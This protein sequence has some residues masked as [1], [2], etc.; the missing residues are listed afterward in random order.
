[1][2]TP[3]ASATIK[4]IKNGSIVDIKGWFLKKVKVRNLD[5]IVNANF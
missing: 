1:M 2:K 4:S 3:I 5:S